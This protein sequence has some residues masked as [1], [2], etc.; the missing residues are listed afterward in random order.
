MIQRVFP[1]EIPVFS[2]PDLIYE[3]EN[4]NLYTEHM[5]Y[6]TSPFSKTIE[7]TELRGHQA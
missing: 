1:K 6:I 4:T 5:Y 2:T 7:I 3:N